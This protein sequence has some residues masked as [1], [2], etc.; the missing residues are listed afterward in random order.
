[1]D[2]DDDGTDETYTLRIV[3]TETEDACSEEN[4]SQTACGIVVEFK[5][6]ITTYAMKD[7]DTNVGGWANSNLRTYLNNTL[8][9]LD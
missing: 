4:F 1:M 3:N 5:E 9:K 6:V 8:L 2:V 7:T